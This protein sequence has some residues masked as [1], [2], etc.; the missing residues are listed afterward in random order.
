MESLWRHCFLGVTRGEPGRTGFTGD[1]REKRVHSYWCMIMLQISHNV[2]IPDEELQITAIRAQG[3]GG[4]H[5]NKVASAVH[6]R[7]DIRSSC[8][9]DF[10]KKRLLRLQDH[11]LTKS[12]QIIIKAQ[13]YRSFEKNRADALLRLQSLIRDAAVVSAK[14]KATRPSMSARQKRR[15]KKSQRGRIKKLR[16]KV[17]H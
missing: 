9:P 17:D 11:R 2:V 4:Q 1:C 3:A 8:L 14:R 13:R 15:E 7:F 12:G 6:L 10:Y 5:V 16:G